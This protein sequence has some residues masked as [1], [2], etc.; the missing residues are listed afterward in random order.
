[1]TGQ[2]T[3]FVADAAVTSGTATVNALATSFHFSGPPPAGTAVAR[4]YVGGRFSTI[5]S[6]VQQNFAI[7]NPADG[8]PVSA[9]SLA[10]NGTVFTIAIAG[11]GP[12]TAR[13]A[14]IGGS[15]NSASP[16]VTTRHNLAAF[17]EGG[18]LT[19]W[20]PNANNTVTAMAVG[21]AN[22]YVGGAFDQVGN[23]SHS[24]LAAVNNSDGALISGWNGSVSNTFPQFLN[25][26]SM[27]ATGSAVYVAGR[28]T[29]ANSAARSDLAAFDPATGDV[30][31]SWDPDPPGQN[32]A[33]TN[34]SFDGAAML[35]SGEFDEIGG[36]LRNH[37][38]A[39]DLSTGQ[40]T[41]FD[42]NVNGD[43]DALALRGG[44][45][46]AGGSFTTVGGS[47]ARR[48][49]AA[50]DTATSQATAWDP[51]VAGT[52]YALSPAGSTVFMG[53]EFLD[54]NGPTTRAGLAEVDAGT[55]ALTPFRQD[56]DGD[57]RA[58]LL[59]DGTLYV[60]GNF[61]HVGTEARSY[62]AAIHPDPG[63]TGSV[64]SF[65]LSPDFVVR[66]LLARGDTVYLA[67]DFQHVQG[68]TPRN[69]VAAFD[70]GTG[71]LTPFDPNVDNPTSSLAADDTDLFLAGGSVTS[72]SGVARQTL[73]SVDFGTGLASSW[74]P[75]LP[76]PATAGVIGL[77]RDGGVVVGGYALAIG[78]E[79]GYLA[80]F[81][82]QPAAPAAPQATAGVGQA[83]VSFA[84]PPNGGSPIT[85]YTVTA[86]PGGQAASGSTNPIT[87][88]GLTPG[89]TYTLTVNAFNAA[90]E[91]VASP[92]SNPVTPTALPATGSRPGGA[93]LLRASAFK[94]THKR[95]AVAKGRTALKAK[96]I[97]G[98]AF[99]FRLSAKAATRIAIARQLAGRK[100]G[101]RCV[102]PRKRLR[103]RCTRS[104]LMGTLIRTRT[105]AGANK[106]P[107]SGRMGERALR[108]GT[109]KATL[110]ATDAAGNRSKPLSLVF[111]V[112]RR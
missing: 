102:A 77:S 29:G 112:V 94:V 108:R 72:V 60:G 17:T 107:F 55:G 25:V 100:K 39:L 80:A 23:A 7:L 2:V 35:V 65:N 54:V 14:Y 95:F 67:G 38:A 79:G 93:A 12:F 105:K 71:A 36:P 62:L 66:S 30:L 101:K 19:S 37:L 58:L 69:H 4:L 73:A 11:G 49:A 52:V 20:D 110:V 40:V 88:T 41:P 27:V 90:G 51:N 61:T 42:P 104:K 70:A 5:N 74:A 63:G 64:T 103:R 109:Y 56:L 98:T 99:T 6:D 45:L 3:S 8:S 57:A 34:L 18:T 78:S 68:G 21:G 89:T 48:D 9:S 92:P 15:F 44:T 46:Y 33:V 59:K 106:V 16:A 97:R 83:S 81:A 75:T 86:S 85:A 50:F 111:T 96:A 10:V 82:L 13:T 24:H 53:G 1:M 87:V 22:V 91:G 76:G 28:F 32:R 26:R 47:L 31:S 84:A 43:V